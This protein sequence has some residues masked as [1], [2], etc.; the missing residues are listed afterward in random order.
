MP[1]P[2]MRPHFERIFRE[3]PDWLP[4]F[5]GYY[6]GTRQRAVPLATRSRATPQ[7]TAAPARKRATPTKK[8][9]PR[10]AR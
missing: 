9:P 10:A 3:Q 4:T 8:S 7:P 1:E 2:E 5:L 6:V